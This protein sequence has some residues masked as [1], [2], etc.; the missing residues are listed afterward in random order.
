MASDE[1]GTVLEV[2][3]TNVG[4]TV[5]ADAIIGATSIALTD[6]SMFDE[7]GGQ[8]YIDGAV[9]YYT[10]VV[11]TGGGAT[12]PAA[13]LE[14]TTGESSWSTT[15]TPK[16]VVVS[17]CLTG[18]WLAVIAGGDQSAGS[19]VTAVT[20]TT[21]AGTTTAW[22]E[23]AE[24]LDTNTNVEWYHAAA[25]Q[26]SADGSVTVQVSRTQSPD[27][28]WGFLVIR[29]RS[30]GGVTLFGQQG[31][32]GSAQAI[33]GA[34][35]A[36][37][38]VVTAFFDWRHFA[39]PNDWTPAGETV[40]ESSEEST[41]TVAAAYWTNQPT[42]FRAYG[43]TDWTS[44]NLKGVGL[45]LL[46]PPAGVAPTLPTSG[47]M[48]LLTGLSVAAVV[49]ETRVEIYPPA[50]IRTAMVAL[51]IEEGESVRVTIPYYVDLP[52]GARPSGERESVLIE[53]RNPGELYLK[54]VPAK[55]MVLLRAAENL[56]D[57]TAQGVFIQL[58]NADA[59]SGSN[60]PTPY[61]GVLEVLST[62]P[63]DVVVQRYTAYRTTA[64]ANQPSPWVR[65]FGEG[66]WSAWQPLFR[67]Y[68]YD[69]ATCTTD[70]TFTVATV[71]DVIGASLSV[72]V[73]ST[74]DVFWVDGVFEIQNITTAGGDLTGRLSVNGVEQ[75]KQILWNSTSAVGTRRTVSQRWRVTG[76]TAGT[77]TFK[78]TVAG[79]I[80]VYQINTTR[81]TIAVEQVVTK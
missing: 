30:C 40:I 53:E 22:T 7:L 24:D 16:T 12:T 20:T 13:P 63:S 74:S 2:S 59:A 31:T 32:G 65:A 34:P 19:G 72:P 41:Y 14:V 58:Y 44:D 52:D 9:Y 70:N 60:Y 51:G 54:D 10:A 37:S 77:R 15:T 39:A 36:G 71:T 27:G 56:D 62:R 57:Y 8:V 29:G 18:D 1:Y 43:T 61:A 21:T 79:P 17:G 28:Q 35:S 76:V 64:T 46:A 55:G 38:A 68:Y 6:V 81:T 3:T 5:A 26:V 42:G 33:N 69:E 45:E 50:P 75:A 66:A 49:D 25:A 80:G 67:G 48:T 47:V 23:L 73:G 4:T 78:L 11:Q